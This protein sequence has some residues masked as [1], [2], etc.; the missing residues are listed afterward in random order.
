M[1]G[2]GG[3]QRITAARWGVTRNIAV[4]WFITVSAAPVTAGLSF[5]L[6]RVV[7]AKFQ[8]KMSLVPLVFMDKALNP[9]EN[10]I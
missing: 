9:D 6:I 3:S 10:R 2:V 5:F 4:A 7:H 8:C 1:M